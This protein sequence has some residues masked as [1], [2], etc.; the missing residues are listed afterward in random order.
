MDILLPDIPGNAFIEKP[1]SYRGVPGSCCSFIF[2]G[3]NMVSIMAT[4]PSI[5]F[6]N[7]YINFELTFAAMAAPEREVSSKATKLA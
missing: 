2:L 1:I 7:I 6:V 4:R 5:R 3:L